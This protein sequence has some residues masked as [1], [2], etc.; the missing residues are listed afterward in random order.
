MARTKEKENRI[1]ASLIGGG[2]LGASIGGIAGAII[3][4]IIG[5]IIAEMKN[6]EEKI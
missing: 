2:I 1:I 5:V 3:G 4:A 6:R